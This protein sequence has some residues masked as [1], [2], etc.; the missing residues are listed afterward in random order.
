ME[1]LSERLTNPAIAAPL[2][3]FICYVIYSK[4]TSKSPVPS[5]LPWIGRDSSKLFSE[6][7]AAFNSFSN[8]RKWLAE[9]Y[10]KVRLFSSYV[11]TKLTFICYSIRNKGRATSSLTSPA[12]PKSSSPEPQCNGSSNN[13]TTSSPPQQST[14]TYSLVT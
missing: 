6:T 3:F 12:N 8:F 7:R 11:A 4:A 1:A 9:G 10:E 5:D 14:T 2:I 13:P